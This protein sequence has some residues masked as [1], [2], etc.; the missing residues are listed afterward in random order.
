MIL[1]IIY[2]HRECIHMYDTVFQAD[3]VEVAVQVENP[4]D[5]TDKMTHVVVRVKSD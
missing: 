3:L 2:T 5:G 4:V 1:F